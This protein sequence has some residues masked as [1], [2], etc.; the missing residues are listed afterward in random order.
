MACKLNGSVRICIAC[1]AINE[2][3]IRAVFSVPRIY[4]LIDK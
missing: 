1:R 2:R 4:D 3:A